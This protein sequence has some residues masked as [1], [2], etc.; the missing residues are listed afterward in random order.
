MGDTAVSEQKVVETST[1]N[2]SENKE[3]SKTE[4]KSTSTKK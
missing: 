1:I 3:D 2:S 4:S